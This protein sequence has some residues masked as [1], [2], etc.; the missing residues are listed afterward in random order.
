VTVEALTT[1]WRKLWFRLADAAA[2]SEH[3]FC[4]Q[5]SRYF[6]AIGTRLMLKCAVIGFGV[7]ARHKK[8]GN[9]I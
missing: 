7:I 8:W 6:D 1:E 2:A 3:L 9:P 5:C 4:D